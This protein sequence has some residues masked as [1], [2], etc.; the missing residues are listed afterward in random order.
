MDGV[1]K[2]R[3]GLAATRD[4]PPE[5]SRPGVV[6]GRCEHVPRDLRAMEDDA[7]EVGQGELVAGR[8]G[9][10]QVLPQGEEDGVSEGAAGEEDGVERAARAGDVRRPREESVGDD[11]DRG[12]D[13]GDEPLEGGAEGLGRLEEGDELVD[14]EISEGLGA[15]GKAVV[16]G[17]EG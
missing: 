3:V 16:R 7:R 15:G 6:L 10:R 1:D 14:V 17:H 12:A 4:D 9:A 2:Q 11:A 5:E 13:A 8:E